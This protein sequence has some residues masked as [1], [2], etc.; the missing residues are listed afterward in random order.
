MAEMTTEEML[1]IDGVIRDALGVLPGQTIREVADRIVRDGVLSK[2]RLAAAIILNPEY[3]PWEAAR[4]ASNVLERG[5]PP[6]DRAIDS[7]SAD[8]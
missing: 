6:T 4:L 2:A 1:R 5:V 7:G 8:E 3:A